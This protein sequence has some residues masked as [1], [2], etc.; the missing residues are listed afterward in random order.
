MAGAFWTGALAAFVAT[1]CTG[2]FMA[3]ALGAALVLPVAAAL[4]VF[5]GLG[6]GL[7][8]PFLALGYVP[9]LRRR[10]PKPGAWMEVFRHILAVPMFLTALGLAWVLGNQTSANGVVVAVGAAMLLAIGLWITGRRQRRFKAGA[11][12]PATVALVL[13]MGAITLVPRGGAKAVAEATATS[14]PFDAAKLAALQAEGKPVFLY[15]TA[16]W[17]LSCKVNEKT[18]I[19]RA[20]TQDAFRAA[21]VTTMVGDWTDGDAK[22]GKFL[23]EHGRSG[24]P[25]YLW[26]APG[27]APQELPQILTPGL[28]AGLAKG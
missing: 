25:L 9:A 16:D 24:V 3:A 12:M 22:I 6:L 20:E 11:W 26:Y 10:L 5:A 21:G 19:E 1:P 17:C 28:L 7:A 27:K 23:E 4:V 13:A 14:Q 15:F 2:P 8:L 18:A